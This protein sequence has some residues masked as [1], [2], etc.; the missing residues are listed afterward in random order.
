MPIYD[1]DH[2]EYNISHGHV[3]IVMDDG[4]QLPAYWA[5]PAMGRK[6]PGTVLIHDWWGVTDM[7]RRLAN[8]FAQTGYYVMVPDLFSGQTPKTPQEAIQLV[9]N[10]EGLGYRQIDA[11]LGALEHHHQS[12]KKVA[13]VGIGMGGSLAFEAAIMRQDLEAA[14]SYGGFPHRYFGQFKD[15]PTPIFAMYGEAEPYVNAHSIRQLRDEL[16]QSKFDLPH[17][18]EIVR[19]LAH[20]FFASNFTDKQRERSRG[21]L[22]ETFAFLDK[23]LE[24]VQQP[25]RQ[26]Y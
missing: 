20:D 18:V 14:I 11:A 4:R 12:N 26:V 13:A 1:P 3:Q 10:L 17:R 5:H 16:A 22:K 8:L 25:P 19:D 15:A 9:K 23:H 24:K 2:V 21:V 6:F 7:V